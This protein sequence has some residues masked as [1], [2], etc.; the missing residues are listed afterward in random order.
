MSILLFYCVSLVTS[1]R[2]P[3]ATLAFLYAGPGTGTDRP[4]TAA[5]T[6]APTTATTERPDHV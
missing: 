2:H 5:T 6:A 3:D 1:N 4:L